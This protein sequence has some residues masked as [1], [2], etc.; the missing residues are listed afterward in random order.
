MIDGHKVAPGHMAT[1][2]TKNISNDDQDEFQNTK[3]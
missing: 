3:V 2:A 1:N